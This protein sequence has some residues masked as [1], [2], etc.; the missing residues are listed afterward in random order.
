V[1]DQKL[2]PTWVELPC[3]HPHAAGLDIGVKEIVACVPVDYWTPPSRTYGAY[4]PGVRGAPS[5]DRSERR[6]LSILRIGLYA[7]FRRCALNQHFDIR[8]CPGC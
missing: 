8:L 4:T 2:S 1:S 5:A 3:I 7:I 6:D